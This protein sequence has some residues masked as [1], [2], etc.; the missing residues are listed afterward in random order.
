M[1]ESEKENL[2][3]TFKGAIASIIEDK[4]R[5][6]KNVKLIKEFKAKFNLGLQMEEDCYFWLN[7]TA[8]NGNYALER[9]KLE[10]YDLVI[11]V[12]PEDLLY[13][14]NRQNSTIHMVKKKNKFGKKKFRFGKSSEGKRKPGILLKLPKVLVLD[15]IKQQK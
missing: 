13:W 4:L 12:V 14:L 10:E 1:E 5:N 15:K 9:G 11:L 7:I 6:P 3:I 2:Y 8:E